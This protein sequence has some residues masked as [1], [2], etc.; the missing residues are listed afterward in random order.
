[1]AA[2]AISK[3]RILQKLGGGGIVYKAKDTKVGRAA[4]PRFDFISGDFEF[5]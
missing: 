3:Y 2:R 1:M 5:E 4:A